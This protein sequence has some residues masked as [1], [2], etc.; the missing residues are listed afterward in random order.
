MQSQHAPNPLV[1]LL[2]RVVDVREDEVRVLLL[3]CAYFFLILASYYIIRPLRDEMGVA[4]GV[5]NIPWL[6]TGTLVGMLIFHP[7]FAALVA[8]LPRRRF[9]SITYR[10]F[11]ANLLIF[12]VLL[13]L[14]PESQSVWAGRA[15]FIWTSVFNL[16][17]VSVFWSFMADVYRLGQGK[18]LFGFIGVGGTI[19]A[20]VGSAI[21]V[22]L[23]ERL[24]P[25]N[26][27]IASIVL[28]ELAV[29]CVNG[30]SAYFSDSAK[31]HSPAPTGSATVPLEEE[32]LRQ[33]EKMTA[34]SSETPIG[35]GVLAGVTSVMRS[36]Y[37]L[38]IVGYMLLYTVAATFLYIQ[39][40]DIIE[41]AF[42]D[43][44]QRTVVF[45]KIDLA[46]NVLTVLT[47]MF[48]TGRIIKLLGVGVTLTLLP[49]VCIVGFTNLGLMPTLGVLIVFQ[50]LRRASNYAVA[51]PTR[52]TLYTV[53][54]REDKYKAKNFI[55]TFVY[56]GGD[57]IGAWSYALM[58]WLGLGLAA[59]AF[60]A[61]PICGLWL[62]IGLWLGREQSAKAETGEEA[63]AANVT[64][65]PAAT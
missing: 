12:F 2:Q 57:Q 41:Q 4:G 45:A 47:Q 21:T 44:A 59:I 24:G 51:R 15:F 22:G 65:A 34:A 27:L 42:S 29:R 40:A 13:K 46:V 25:I 38:G 6:F 3:S 55:D 20:I 36:P 37:L 30:L 26:L 33:R 61:V 1:R 5:R 9:I 48:L 18:R 19:G 8:R 50:V 53:V 32:A 17:V 7:P 10:F 49:A 43:R 39:Q 62:L 52:E 60:V 11:M 56:R 16:F 63:G 23:A 54:P 28:L 31:P 58:Q 35:G 64:P 14:T